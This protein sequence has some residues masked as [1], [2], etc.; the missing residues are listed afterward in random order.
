MTLI[1]RR[2][3]DED[4]YF[5]PLTVAIGSTYR[6][7]AVMLSSGDDE[8]SA[9]GFRISIGGATVIV[10][11]PRWLVPTE[12]KKVYPKSW[13]Q[14]TI[15]RLGRDWY[16]DQTIRE[17]GVSLNEGF[18]NLCYGRQTHDSSTEQRSGWFLPWT[19]WRFVRHSLYGLDGTHF[20]DLPD[21]GRRLDED[22]W[23]TRQDIS[24]ACPSASFDFADFDGEQLTAATKI[25]ERE[26]LFG[27]GW[28]KW[29]SLFRA[30]KVR[31]SLD[32]NFSGETGR[33][34]G[35]WKGGT[36]GSGIDMLLGE[37]HAAAFERYCTAHDMKPA[38]PQTSP[39][40]GE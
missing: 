34:K 22:S 36:I 28:F 9:A 17:Y 33:R 10:A 21:Y 37:L 12:R 7:F 38:R 31:R 29:L 11:L 23:K 27:T 26:W 32:I 4:H 2:W 15:N 30:P 19:Q 39:L 18:L 35:S 13:D 40:N 14:A 25:E 8:G 24:D 16:W 6:H 20:A 5:G 3:S 1:R